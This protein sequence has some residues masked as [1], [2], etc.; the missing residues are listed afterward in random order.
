MNPYAVSYRQYNL[1]YSFCQTVEKQIVNVH[2]S[3]IFLLSLNHKHENQ[4]YSLVFDKN[5]TFYF[6]K[7]KTSKQKLYLQ[8]L[9][10]I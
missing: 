8:L 3:Y 1:R 6:E 2:Q 5:I 7:L 10:K 9:D 4:S